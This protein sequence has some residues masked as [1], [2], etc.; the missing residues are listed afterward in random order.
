MRADRFAAG[1]GLRNPV[2]MP[3]PDLR[4]ND[5]ADCGIAQ[6]LR[7]QQVYRLEAAY[8]GVS[9]CAVEADRSRHWSSSSATEDKREGRRRRR[10]ARG[11]RDRPA[12]P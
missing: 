10:V 6:Q 4:G 2:M 8:W 3:N 11:G 9:S 5:Q 12:L 7:G 1:L